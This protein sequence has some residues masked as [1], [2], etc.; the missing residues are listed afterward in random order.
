VSKARLITFTLL[1]LLNYLDR[2]LVQALLP[3]ISLHYSLTYEESGLL[4]S[5][6]V[7]GYFITAPVFGILGDRWHRPRLMAVG[8]LLWSAATV[9]GGLADLYAAFFAL[10]LLVGVGEASFGTI[11][12][13]YI[14]DGL[15]DPLKVNKAFS[16]LYAAIPVG[17]AL[18]YV[19]GGFV[20]AHFPWQYAFFL[21]GLPGL[22]LGLWVWKL[23]EY[24]PSAA[25]DSQ[26][27][28]LGGGAR[29]VLA[30]L[31]ELAAVP[32]IWF[33]IIGYA[34]NS[35]ALNA[36][37]TFVAHYGV[38]LGFSHQEVT[39]YFGLILVV[40]GF[41]G[42]LCG[43]S[44]ADK[45]AKRYSSPV[46]SML[47]FVGVTALMAV[48]FCAAAFLVSS[49]YGFLA[50]CAV[51]QL[52]IFAGVAPINSVLVL[53]APS[54]LVTLVQGVAIFALN[55]L[56]ALC[57]PWLVGRLADAWSLASALQLSTVALFLCGVVWCA[58]GRVAGRTATA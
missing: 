34:L 55:A 48:P 40:M 23:P 56:G 22:I 6:F 46:S 9:G 1:N 11:L 39:Q 26:G 42:T 31:R 4:A 52:L 12:P 27:S 35:F 21:G 24:R 15:V 47:K 51:A 43:G 50:L 45:F 32:V 57:A 13:G 33:A 14:K 16:I 54:H 17:S 20:A 44:V 7:F 38:A 36:I 18:A 28:N 19:L 41:V 58:G 49:H 8:I 25:P 2:Y 53:A 29:S 37:A 30:D 5:A 3:L 10:R